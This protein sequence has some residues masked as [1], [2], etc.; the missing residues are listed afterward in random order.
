MLD[1]DDVTV[2]YCVQNGRKLVNWNMNIKERSKEEH[3][4]GTTVLFRDCI[5]GYSQ[6]M[7][8]IEDRA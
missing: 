1:D 4:T 7:H 2:D 5:L 6:P 3:S 8:R